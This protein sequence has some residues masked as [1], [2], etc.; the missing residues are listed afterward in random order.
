VA[1]GIWR[2]EGRSGEA[3][4]PKGGVANDLER[5]NARLKK[6]VADLALD[7]AI[8]QETSKLILSPSRRREAIEQVRRV[9]P[10]SER[11]TCRVLGQH[12]S[13]RRHPPKDDADEQRLTADIVALAKHYGRYGYRRIHALLGHAGWPSQTAWSFEFRPPLVRPICRGTSPF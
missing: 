12:R 8:L 1:Q 13:T 4:D 6:L 5:E 9:L 10:V 3:D 7:K 2:P 11:R